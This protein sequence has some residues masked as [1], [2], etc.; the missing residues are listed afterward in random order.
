MANPNIVNVANIYGNTSVLAVSTVA[1][2]VVQ[3]S[4]TSSSL[5]KINT[6]TVANINAYSSAVAVTVQLN[7]AGTLTTLA[8]SMVVPSNTS[9]VIMGKDTPIYLLENHSIQ[10]TAGSNNSLTA[11]IS[12]EQIS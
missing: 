8:Q 11:I 5:Y 4:A 9:L 7:Q 3:N 10:L 6:L 12:Y 2:N 1:S